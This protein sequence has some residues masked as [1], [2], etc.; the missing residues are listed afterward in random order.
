MNKKIL[1][2]L[3]GLVTGMLCYGFGIAVQGPVEKK[4]FELGA[5]KK[6]EVQTQY[7]VYLQQGDREQITVETYKSIMPYVTVR[8]NAYGLVVSLDRKLRN[9]RWMNHDK[10]LN[11]YITVKD[12]EE[13]RLSG[14]CDL[15]MLNDLRSDQIQIRASGASDLFLKKINGKEI[16]ILTSGASDIKHGE[17]IANKKIYINSSGACDAFLS[18]NAPEIEIIASGSSDFDLEVQ[19][20]VLM[21]KSS[22]SSDFDVRGRVTRLLASISGSSML[23]AEALY[24]EDVDIS[25]SGTSESRV[26]VTGYLKA[27]SSGTASIY[28]TGE[29]RETSFR[30]SGISSIRSG[31]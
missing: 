31:K 6:I 18:L 7:N 22:G 27:E 9:I 20:G 19:A 16:R 17:L 5:F 28:Y 12:L 23:Q 15:H 25:T 14:A 24:T 4:E 1:F 21:L 11:V 26:Y 13:I 30:I 3:C 8:K 10:V 2:L 29:P